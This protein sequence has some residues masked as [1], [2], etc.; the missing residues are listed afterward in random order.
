[1]K[2]VY[3]E[4][5]SSKKIWQDQVIADVIVLP[6]F[7]W[8]R[9]R[10]INSDSASSIYFFLEHFS[11]FVAFGFFVDSL[12]KQLNFDFDDHPYAIY[13]ARTKANATG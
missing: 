3:K 13:Q 7:I 6:V 2:I 1:M 12:G 8:I 5:W 10:F 9:A 4:K 11:L